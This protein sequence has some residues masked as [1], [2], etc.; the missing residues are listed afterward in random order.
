MTTLSPLTVDAR[1]TLRAGGEPFSDIMAAV[2][3]LTPGQALRLLATFKPVPL[4]AVMARQ[5]FAHEE[6]EIGDGDWEVLFTPTRFKPAAPENTAAATVPASLDTR[7]LEPPEPM[8]RVLAALAEMPPGATLEV[9]TEREP[10]FLYQELAARG[11]SVNSEPLGH[12]GFR[13]LIRV[14]AKAGEPR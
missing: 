12:E 10:I 4:F 3:R 7:G 9:Y 5:G 1:P 2:A 6:R 13:H 11:H 14:A 8:V